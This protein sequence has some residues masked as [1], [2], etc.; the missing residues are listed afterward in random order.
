MLI[1]GSFSVLASLMIEKNLTVANIF[2]CFSWHF[3][4]FQGITTFFYRPL[5]RDLLPGAFKNA[6]WLADVSFTLAAVLE[7][8]LSY[9]YFKEEYR[10]DLHVARADA[11]ASLMFFLSASIYIV[12]TPVLFAKNTKDKPYLE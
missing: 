1:A 6:M 4:A 8:V 3:F 9:I 11:F 5:L 10:T 2:H 12:T 7:A